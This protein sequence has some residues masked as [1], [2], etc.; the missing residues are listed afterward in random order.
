MGGGSRANVAGTIGEHVLEFTA[1][2]PT[3]EEI[4]CTPD[5]DL[6]YA[7]IS[8]VGVLGVFTS[9]TLKMKRVYSGNLWVEA[10]ASPNL[11]R[12]V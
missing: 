8:G 4:T 5:D 9:I 12:M 6:F 1:L 3:G 2:L 10:W 11:R 7:M